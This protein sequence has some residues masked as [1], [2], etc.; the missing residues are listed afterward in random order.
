MGGATH[1]DVKSKI[2]STKIMD[3]HDILGGVAFGSR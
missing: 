3:D 2:S 1:D